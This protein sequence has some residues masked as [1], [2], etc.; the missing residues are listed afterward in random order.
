ML[1]VLLCLGILWKTWVCVKISVLPACHLSV[2]KRYCWLFFSLFNFKR[3][4]LLNFTRRLPQFSLFIPLPVWP[5]NYCIHMGHQNLTERDAVWVCF[6]SGVWLAFVWTGSC[7][8]CIFV[9]FGGYGIINCGRSLA[10]AATFWALSWIFKKLWWLVDLSKMC[11]RFIEN[12]DCFPWAFQKKKKNE[13]H[14]ILGDLG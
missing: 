4:D 5:C 10:G 13:A 7:T 8:K 14:A 12:G 9:N 2:A 3:N 1:L 6:Y 11:I